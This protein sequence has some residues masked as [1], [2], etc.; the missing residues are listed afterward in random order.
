MTR[1][2]LRWDEGR[3]TF[4]E[5]SQLDHSASC[6]HRHSFVVVSPDCIAPRRG[7]SHPPTMPLSPLAPRPPSPRPQAAS[8]CRSTPRPRTTRA[9]AAP[10]ARLPRP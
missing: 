6:W 5:T 10:R 3:A 1:L 9:R 4:E 7:T 2:S 8:R